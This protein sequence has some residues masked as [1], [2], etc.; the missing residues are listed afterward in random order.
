MPDGSAWQDLREAF[1]AYARGRRQL[2]KAIGV[3]ASNRDPLSEFSERLVAALLDGELATN[4]VQR[5]WDL[6]TPEG[7]RVQVKYLAN[8]GRGDPWINGIAISFGPGVDDPHDF[9]VVFFEALLP[10]SVIVFGREQVLEVCTRLKKRHPSQDRLLQLTQAN[11]RQLLAERDAF[12]S[13]GVRVID[14]ASVAEE[15]VEA[16]GG[17]TTGEV[18]QDAR[19][20]TP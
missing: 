8:P 13:L 10:V 17:D 16:G 19:D 1:S 14:L 11:Y 12:A 2:L 5:G 18:S 3:S 15:L 6:R 7:R 20:S 4:R 9:V